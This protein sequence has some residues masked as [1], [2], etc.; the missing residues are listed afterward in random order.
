MGINC[1]IWLVSLY[2]LTLQTKGKIEIKTFLFAI[3]NLN[4]NYVGITKFLD[5]DYV[6]RTRSYYLIV[7]NTGISVKFEKFYGNKTISTE[8]IYNA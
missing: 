2:F 6:R 5:Q 4:Q 7:S 3:T 8:I 1:N